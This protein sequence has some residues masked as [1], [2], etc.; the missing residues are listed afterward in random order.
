[1]TNKGVVSQAIFYVVL[2]VLQKAVVS[3]AICHV[4]L[5]VLQKAVVSQ[6]ICHFILLEDNMTNTLRHHS[7]L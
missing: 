7:F 1:M 6:A 5:L 4:I 3:Q 2:L